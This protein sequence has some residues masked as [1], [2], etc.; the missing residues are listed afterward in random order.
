VETAKVRFWLPRRINAHARREPPVK[1]VRLN[2][3]RQ[4]QHLA[5]QRLGLS[6]FP[7]AHVRQGNVIFRS[8]AARMPRPQRV[9]SPGQLRVGVE[10]G[11]VLQ[12]P[13][14]GVYSDQDSEENYKYA[15][16]VVDIND[17]LK[18]LILIK[19]TRPTDSAGTAMRTAGNTARSWS[20]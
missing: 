3:L 20:G 7:L 17:P 4:L 19:P 14:A 5:S 9:S 12:G 11:L 8:Q 2:L 13:D 6:V 15:M 16:H 1:V 10:R 18:S